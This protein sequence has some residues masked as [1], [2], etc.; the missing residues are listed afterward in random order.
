MIDIQKQ[1]QIDQLEARANESELL[2]YLARDKDMR[3]YNKRLA[4]EL[5]EAA[6]RFRS[7][8]AVAA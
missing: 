1:G 4:L 5:R 7:K 8:I 3:D 6:L 2:A